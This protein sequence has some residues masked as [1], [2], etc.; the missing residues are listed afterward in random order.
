RHAAAAAPPAADT[1]TAA[2]ASPSL[3]RPPASAPAPSTRA[4]PSPACPCPAACRLPPLCPEKEKGA[5]R[6]AAARPHPILTHLTHDHPILSTRPRID[7]AGRKIN[8]R[9]T[10]TRRKSQRDEIARQRRAITP[11]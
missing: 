11:I 5:V 10:E 7:V 9:G 6:P 4:P 8:H 3:S 2:P 1:R